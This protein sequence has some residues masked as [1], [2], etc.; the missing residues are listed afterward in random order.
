MGF[1]PWQKK[2]VDHQPKVIFHA[3][4]ASNQTN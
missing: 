1:Q 3:F 4:V 2:I